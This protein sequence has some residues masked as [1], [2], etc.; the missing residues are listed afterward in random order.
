MAKRMTP[1]MERIN[2][3]NTT[4]S[5][6]QK[7]F[8]FTRDAW[9]RFKRNKTAVIGLVMIVI[10]LLVAAFAPWLCPYDYTETDYL[11]ANQKPSAEHWFGTDNLGRDLFSRCIYGTRISVPLGII[12]MV[13]GCLTGGFLG[14]VAAYFAG[15]TDNIIMRIMDVLQAIPGTLLAIVVIATLGNGTTQLV[16]ALLISSMPMMAK[17]FRAAIF[18]VRSAD[19]MESC[20]SIGAGNMRLMIHHALPNA[21]GHIIIFAVSSIPSTIMIITSLSYIGLGIQPPAPEWGALLSAGKNYFMSYGYMVLYPGLMIM[22]TVLAF[23]L[24]GDGLRDALDPR[25]K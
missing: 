2:K 17:T 19:Y 4:R 10:I 9:M 20:R 6:R 5:G 13:F 21:L 16:I 12:C 23:N 1:A 3:A 8:T 15:A 22:F 18:T 7:E 25:L 11:A 24:F 14:M